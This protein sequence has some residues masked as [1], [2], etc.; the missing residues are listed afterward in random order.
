MPQNIKKKQIFINE[1]A[2]TWSFALLARSS[3]PT[4]LEGQQNPK[5]RE[6][7]KQHRPNIMQIFHQFTPL[8]QSDGAGRRHLMW[9]FRAKKISVWPNQIIIRFQERFR[10]N[11]F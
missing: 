5:G 11:K 9:F 8:I 1:H 3:E 7:T 2:A 6:T 10:E 4:E